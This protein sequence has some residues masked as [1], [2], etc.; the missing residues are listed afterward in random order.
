[1][2]D[3]ASMS[4]K[5]LKAGIVA[6]IGQGA[7]DSK[8][9]L[10]KS[11]FVQCLRDLRLT[12]W[13][14]GPTEG[15]SSGGQSR[16]QDGSFTVPAG[17]YIL[18]D[19][20]YLVLDVL[21]LELFNETY[22]DSEEESED[23]PPQRGSKRNAPV[24]EKPTRV[25]RFDDANVVTAFNTVKSGGGLWFSDHQRTMH[26]L[27]NGGV[28]ALVPLSYNPA[29]A[30]TDGYAHVVEFTKAVNC[31]EKNGDVHFGHITINTNKIC[32]PKGTAPSAPIRKKSRSKS[33]NKYES[34]SESEDQSEESGDEEEDFGSDESSDSSDDEEEEEWVPEK[35]QKHRVD[36][37][38]DDDDDD[39]YDE[40]TNKVKRGKTSYSKVKRENPQDDSEG[41][42]DKGGRLQKKSRPADSDSEEAEF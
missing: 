18:G 36:D 40:N 17:K 3:P 37:D 14:K 7:L 15:V 1:M 2:A 20:C 29:F 41:E 42:G 11:E 31:F 5:E 8:K 10:E 30:S 19:P 38:D 33:S 23:S 27:I 34:E 28:I 21:H 16:N 13:N 24:K 9:F 35:K 25:A 22:Y 4:I 26:F 39:D 6:F 12:A 32:A